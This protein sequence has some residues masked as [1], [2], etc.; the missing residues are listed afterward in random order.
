[1]VG[2]RASGRGTGVFQAL[3]GHRCPGLGGPPKAELRLGALG[4]ARCPEAGST[5]FDF[6]CLLPGL[7]ALE[8]GQQ[9][10]Q[11]GPAQL[12]TFETVPSSAGWACVPCS[13][14]T[15]PPRPAHARQRGKERTVAGK[16]LPPG[17]PHVPRRRSWHL[18]GQIPEHPLQ[19]RRI[20]QMLGLR[21]TP[22]ADGGT[23]GFPPHPLQLAG[24]TQRRHRLEG[25]IEQ[26]KEK[27]TQIIRALQA[28][29]LIR[30]TGMQSLLTPRLELVPKSRQQIPLP[31]ICRRDFEFAHH[32]YR[33]PQ[34]R[35]TYIQTGDNCYDAARVMPNTNGWWPGG[36]GRLPVLPGDTESATIGFPILSI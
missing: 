23:A 16:P 22:Q 19:H 9:F 15:R 13:T 12:G 10:F 30:P 36:T 27:Q 29:S 20:A 7:L 31:E 24:R 25:G 11:A 4:A 17:L 35:T 6:A 32:A 2:G 21:K 18:A 26:P 5:Y 8:S 3:K 28:P 33:Q 1:M 34:T 14:A